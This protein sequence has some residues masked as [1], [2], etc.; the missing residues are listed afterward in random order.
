M[1]FLSCQLM[2]NWCF[3]GWWFFGFLFGCPKVTLPFLG[4]GVL[5]I[6]LFS[7]RS[8]EKSSN[9]TNIFISDGWLNH[10]L[11]MVGFRGYTLDL[12]PTP[13]TFLGSGILESQAK[14]LF[15]W[16]FQVPVKGGRWHII[17]QLAVYTIYIP[18]IYCLLAGYI[19]PTIDYCHLAS[20]VDY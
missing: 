5:N 10:Q 15:Q 13:V 16:I 3:L 6:F 7:C 18:L 1:E 14:P 20:W 17:P 8:L 4:G 9:L 12:P 2:V 11:V 19:I